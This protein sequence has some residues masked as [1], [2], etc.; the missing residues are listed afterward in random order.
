MFALGITRCY[1]VDGWDTLNEYLSNKIML[2][3]AM[4]YG[5]ALVSA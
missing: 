1:M 5:G 4:L 2:Y 3:C